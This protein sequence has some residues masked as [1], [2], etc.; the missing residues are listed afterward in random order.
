MTPRATVA[1]AATL[2]LVA[3]GALPR[4][5]TATGSTRVIAS[6]CGVERWTVKTLQDRP[7]LLP[8]RQTSITFLTRLRAP[9]FLPEARLPIERHV[10]TVRA[11]VV[12][13][14]GEADG[15]CTWCSATAAGR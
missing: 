2:M 11:A 10:Y 1:A 5:T 6:T 3:A 15:T 7:R 4:L 13:I 9:S 12:L 8:P 14:R